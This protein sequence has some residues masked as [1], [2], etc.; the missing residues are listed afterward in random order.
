MRREERMG[1]VGELSLAG[2]GCLLAL[3]LTELSRWPKRTV[4]WRTLVGSS[5]TTP[6]E[7]HTHTHTSV[8]TYSHIGPLLCSV[9]DAGGL[10]LMGVVQLPA[11]PTSCQVPVCP[12]VSI[13]WTSE[14]VL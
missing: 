12:N 5:E 13:T 9:L 6:Q 11:Q 10:L 1:R 2:D 3:A 14:V 7:K 4:L 8:H